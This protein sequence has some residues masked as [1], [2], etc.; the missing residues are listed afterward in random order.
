MKTSPAIL[1][2]VLALASGCGGDGGGGGDLLPAVIPPPPAPVVSQAQN[3]PTAAAVADA[4]DTTTQA[5]THVILDPFTQGEASGVTHPFLAPPSFEF[6]SHVEFEIDLDSTGKNGNDRFPNVSGTL[7]VTVDGLLQ[8]TWLSGEA[9]YSVMIEVGSDVT[10]VD[11]GTDIETLIPQGSSW[12]YALAVTWDITDSQNW[13]VIATATKAIAIEGLTV[14]DGDAVTT[15]GIS[16]GRQVTTAIAKV[17]GVVARE[18]TV[19][20]SF[21]ITIDDGQAVV[22]VLIEFDADGLILVTIGDEQFGPFTPAEFRAFVQ[23]N[24][25]V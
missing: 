2:L 16:G 17:D 21:T 22:E 11:P 8:G 9:S 4:V 15:V 10:A 13:I 20:G 18:R 24:L 25:R 5:V 7:L 6:T 1:A 14:T 19:E 3:V 23:D 12:S